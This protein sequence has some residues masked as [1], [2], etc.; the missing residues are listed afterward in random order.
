M[1]IPKNAS[2]L[3]DRDDFCTGSKVFHCLKPLS[4]TAAPFTPVQRPFFDAAQPRQ[5]A[6]GSAPPFR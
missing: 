3:K 4:T 2:F 5:A 6:L 1:E